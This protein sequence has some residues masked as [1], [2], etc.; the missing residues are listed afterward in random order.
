MSALG[1][2]T[3]SS[4][5]PVQTFPGDGATVSGVPYFAW[6]PQDYAARY[7]VEVYK[8]NDGLWS[9]G[10]RVLTQTTKFA[11]W[12]PTT[13]ARR[14]APTPGA[15]GGSTPT[16]WS[17]RGRRAV[18]STSTPAAP[19]LVSPL[20]GAAFQS[21]ALFFTWGA[22]TGAVQYKFEASNVA[23]FTTLS[24]TQTTV[25]SAW[26]PTTAFGDGDL[27][28]A[29]QGARRRRQHAQH[30]RGADAS[31]STPRSRPSSKT[32]TT[33]RLDHRL[34]LGDVLGAR[35][36]RRRDDLQDVVAGTA[37]AVAGR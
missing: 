25:M 2:L 7:T 1:S 12:A 3:K 10:N 6:D 22:V 26:A 17:G 28:L 16:A 9:P 29:G 23:D 31:P 35:Q 14:R 5:T 20:D 30:L 13:L 32:P 34:V 4:P 11:A 33:G 21:T 24:S 36:G 8:G 15:S 18:A 19:T 27:L 37:T